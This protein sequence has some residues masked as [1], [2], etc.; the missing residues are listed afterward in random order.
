[1][2]ATKGK[3]NWIGLAG[4]ITT[5]VLLG[6]SL[7]IPWWQLTVGEGFLKANAS[8]V[9]TNFGFLDTSFTIPLVLALNVASLLWLL[10]CGIVMLLYSIIPTR[11]YSKQLLG[12]AYTKPLYALIF[13]VAGLVSTVFLVQA[14]IGLKV[15]LMGSTT[16]TLSTGFTQGR[17]VSILMSAEFQWPFWLAVVAAALCIAARLY[18]KKVVAMPTA[19]QTPTL[20]PAPQPRKNIAISYSRRA[21][22]SV[23]PNRF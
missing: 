17:T 7:F 3:I 14:I 13:F 10:A 19:T 22:G 8:P 18:H 5:L 21:R 23:F 6:V 4:G 11:P 12:F 20:T 16:S 9:N 2:K 1:V 15:P